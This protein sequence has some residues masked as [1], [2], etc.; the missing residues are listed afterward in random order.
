VVT[1]RVPVGRT[2]PP[3]PIGE[4]ERTSASAATEEIER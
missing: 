3:Q 1:G 4:I 2:I